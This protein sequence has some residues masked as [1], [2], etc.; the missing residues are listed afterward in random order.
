VI[1]KL[2][3]VMRYMIYDAN[4][5]K[6][7]LAKEI[8][9][10]RHYIGLERLRLREGIPLEFEVC[11]NTDV[12]ISPLILITFLENA[13]KHGVDGGDGDC[14][15]RARLVADENGLRYTISNS[16]AKRDAIPIAGEGIGLSNVKK[17]LALCY[18]NRH[19]LDIRDTNDS[20]FVAL[21]IE[22]P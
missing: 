12:L 19:Q 2:S 11:G 4:Y 8:D 3:E 21:S 14:W 13:F 15:I 5:E 6:V 20:F 1:S 17:R 22:R 7:E 9:Y 16:K 10:M 18:P